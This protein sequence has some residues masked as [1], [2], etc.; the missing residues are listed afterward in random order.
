MPDQ[1]ATTSAANGRKGG[2]PRDWIVIPVHLHGQLSAKNNRCRLAS[3]EMLCQPRYKDVLR[4]LDKAGE[5]RTAERRLVGL[6]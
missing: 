1:R 5:L 6:E 2:R 4:I 3:M